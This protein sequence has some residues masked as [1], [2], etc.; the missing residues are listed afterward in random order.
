MV[1]YFYTIELNEYFGRRLEALAARA[2]YDDVEAF[3][4]LILRYGIDLMEDDMQQAL[5]ETRGF[6]ENPLP[7][8]PQD[9]MDDDI[10]I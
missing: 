9:G 1:E 3:A 5:A 7:G 10:P 2:S 6:S 8:P 4:A